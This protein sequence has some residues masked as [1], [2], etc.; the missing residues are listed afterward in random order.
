[1][2]GM[3][4]KF[5]ITGLP[6]SYCTLVFG[7]PSVRISARIPVIL[8]YGFLWFCL[9]TT[10]KWQ[11]SS[12]IW[13]WLLPSKSFTYHASQ[14]LNII[15]SWWHLK[16]NSK[17]SVLQDELHVKV[18]CGIMYIFNKY[19]VSRKS[20]DTWVSITTV[21]ELDIRVQFLA[22]AKI[23]SLPHIVQT[24][25]GAHP[26][27]F[28][29]VTEGTSPGWWGHGMKVTTHLNLVLKEGKNGGAISLPSYTS[30]GV[31]LNKFNTR[32]T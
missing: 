32:T 4:E 7:M 11:Y 26:D 2:W 10:S 8:R 9:A 18:M 24:G 27:Y 25:S 20:M 3:L 15:C 31:V 23:L 28:P 19:A 13:S 12:L 1:M 22:W 16:T 30:S 14:I 21:Y 17:N 5:V 29:T 6:Q